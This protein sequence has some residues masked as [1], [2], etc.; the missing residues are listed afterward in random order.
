MEIAW[1]IEKEEPQNA[2]TYLDQA[3]E[4]AENLSYSQALAKAY[5]E[6]GAIYWYYIGDYDKALEWSWEAQKIYEKIR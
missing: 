5:N 6:K 1:S 2:L 4:L 3:I